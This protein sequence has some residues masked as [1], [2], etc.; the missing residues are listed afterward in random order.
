MSGNQQRCED[1]EA[2]EAL[3]ADDPFLKQS[4]LS[5]Q[6]YDDCLVAFIDDQ[7]PAEFARNILQNAWPN[8]IEVYC[9]TDIIAGSSDP[10]G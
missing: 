6:V 7:I 1:L 3:V 9:A 5:I 2:I 8:S 10:V 4:I